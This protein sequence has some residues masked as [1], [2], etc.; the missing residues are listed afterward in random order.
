MNNK[1]E[2]NNLKNDLAIRQVMADMKDDLYAIVN[3]ELNALEDFA[4]S[5]YLRTLGTV[6]QY[7]NTPSDLQ[8]LYFKRIVK[9]MTEDE[10]PEDIMKRALEISAKDIRDFVDYLKDKP[11]RFY[12]ALDAAVLTALGGGSQA[13]CEYLAGLLEVLGISKQ[14]LQCISLIAKSIVTQQ[15]SLYDEAKPLLLEDL[16]EVSFFPYIKNYYT[17]AVIDSAYAKEFY[18]PDKALSAEIQYPLTYTQRKVTFKN[19][20]IKTLKNENWHFNGCETVIFE[21][22]DIIESNASFDFDG[23]RRVVFSHC[24]FA[25]CTWRVIWFSKFSICEELSIKNCDFI[26]CIMNYNQEDCKVLGGIVYIMDYEHINKSDYRYSG[27]KFN[28]FVMTDCV[29]HNCGSCNKYNCG[30]EKFP[31]GIIANGINKVNNCKFLSCQSYY[32][33]GDK[34]NSYKQL[35]YL[36]TVVNSLKDSNNNEYPGSI[37]TLYS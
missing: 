37:L 19:L 20:L 6:I 18:A 12:F 32:M 9:G 34:K 2:K 30:N 17:G 14:E 16:A 21:N 5:L 26:N 1:D 8:S 11:A 29:F 23:C 25:D 15:A 33:S 10:S 36:F 28:H 7:D 3:P 35:P 31:T 24:R 13:G 4:K 22:C 27:C